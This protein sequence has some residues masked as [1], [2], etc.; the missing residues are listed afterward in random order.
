MLPLGLLLLALDV[1]LPRP[2][3]SNL[4]I[5]AR[6]RIAVWRHSHVGD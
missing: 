6:R 2:F 4:L 3:V 5:S 1:P